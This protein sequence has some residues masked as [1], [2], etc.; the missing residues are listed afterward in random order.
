MKLILEKWHETKTRAAY[1][2]KNFESIARILIREVHVYYRQIDD[3]YELI[4]SAAAVG[5]C[6]IW[7]IY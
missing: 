4:K 2:A 6:L 5:R 7:L 3:K 1:R